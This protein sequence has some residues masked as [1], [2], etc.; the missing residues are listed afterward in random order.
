MVTGLVYRKS[1]FSRT[2]VTD[3]LPENGSMPSDTHTEASDATTPGPKLRNVQLVVLMAREQPPD[4]RAEVK[5]RVGSLKISS[6][7]FN[8]RVSGDFLNAGTSQRH[9]YVTSRVTRWPPL[10]R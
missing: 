5:A 8:Q 9:G 4:V 10:F 2:A 3:L 1:P 7:S 6:S